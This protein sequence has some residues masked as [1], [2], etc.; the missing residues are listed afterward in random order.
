MSS[1]VNF[2]VNTQLCV[3]CLG[4][5]LERPENIHF[6]PSHCF[7]Q[8]ASSLLPEA[9]QSPRCLVSGWMD[10]G[11]PLSSPAGPLTKSNSCLVLLTF[12]EL[13]ACAGP[14]EGQH[15]P[16]CR[17]PWLFPSAGLPTEGIGPVCSGLSPSRQT[18]QGTSPQPH[19]V[20]L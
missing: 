6:Q 12:P 11:T 8:I 13:K 16:R 2:Y 1:C 3:Q 20:L 9:Q 15:I 19:P 7:G 14:G 17:C 5:G 4:Q 18:R 10:I